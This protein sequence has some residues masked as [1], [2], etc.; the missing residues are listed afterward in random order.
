MEGEREGIRQRAQKET[1]RNIFKKCYIGFCTPTRTI[2]DSEKKA[3]PLRL[4]LRSRLD[5]LYMLVYPRQPF[6]SSHIFRHLVQSSLLIC[7]QSV[8]S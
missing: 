6:V 2:M 3:L 5:L 8:G 1:H 4:L 7:S